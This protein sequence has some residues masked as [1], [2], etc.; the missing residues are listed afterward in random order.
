MSQEMLPWEFKAQ[1]SQRE[2]NKHNRNDKYGMVASDES[3][4]KKLENTIRP[5]LSI[6][7]VPRI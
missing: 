6:T 1:Y 4:G 3:N 5:I 7:W 2:N